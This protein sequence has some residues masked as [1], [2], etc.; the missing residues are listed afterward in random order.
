MQKRFQD[1][2]DKL[3]HGDIKGVYNMTRVLI[4][5][6]G[7]IGNRLTNFIED[8]TI[9]YSRI[10]TIDDIF[11]QIEEYT[12]E[13]VINCVGKTGRPNVDWCELNK[14]ET[15]FSNVTVPSMMAEACTKTDTYMVHIGSGCIYETMTKNDCCSDT[16]FNENDKPNF[17]GSF[18]SRTKIFT[19]K[20]LSEYENILQ[21]RIRMPVDDIPSPRN[22]IDR[23]IKYENV[24]NVPNSITCIPDF[25]AV[26]KQLMDEHETGIFN[27]T[28]SGAITHEQILQMYKNIVD[29]SYKMPE[30]ISLDKLDTVAGRSNCVLYNARLEGK[31]VKMRHVLEAV[32]ECMKN[33]VK[34][35]GK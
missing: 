20:I 19:E 13:V 30:F 24:I 4:F 29:S 2:C 1:Q 17:K 31:G 11:N 25:I 33:Y 8:S 9:S 35:S 32:K 27:V 18:Y 14:D 34:H 3:L 15:F 10:N 21:L 16:G 28:N 12:P 22:L 7:F 6:N 26:V 5:G 23:L